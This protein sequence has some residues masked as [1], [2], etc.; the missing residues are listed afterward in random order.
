MD[1]IKPIYY[2]WIEQYKKKYKNSGMLL[3][4]KN[5]QFQN[6]SSHKKKTL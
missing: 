4:T 2:D 6:Y 5:E 1:P 3:I